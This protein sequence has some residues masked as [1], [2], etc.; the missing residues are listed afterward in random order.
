MRRPPSIL[1]AIATA[2]LASSAPLSAQ[3]LTVGEGPLRSSGALTLGPVAAVNFPTGDA[4]DVFSTGFTIGAQGTYGL[5]VVALLG[6]ITYNTLGDDGVGSADGVAFDAGA[7]LSIPLGGL[8]AGGVAGLWTGDF[9][10][11]F[12]IVPLIGLHLGPVDV[13]AR[14]KGLVGDADWF[15]IGGAVHFRLK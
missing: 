2:L 1:I 9:D 10:S 11:D 13:E 7:R 14:Y 6:E 3:G 15:S 5:G 4:G 12:D 8:Y